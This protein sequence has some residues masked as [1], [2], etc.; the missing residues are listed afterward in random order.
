M[1]QDFFIAAAVP[2]T[3]TIIAGV[4]ALVWGGYAVWSK[5]TGKR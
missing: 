1:T 3:C 2:I 5:W 4:F